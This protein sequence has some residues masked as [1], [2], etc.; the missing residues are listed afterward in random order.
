MS[1]GEVRALTPLL[2][3]LFLLAIAACALPF[4]HPCL[5]SVG[6]D[7]KASSILHVLHIHQLAVCETLP[8]N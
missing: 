5:T 7:A 8:L 4:P 3:L 2:T 6:F 1:A